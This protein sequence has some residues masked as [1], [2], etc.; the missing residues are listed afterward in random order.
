MSR[1]SAKA[2][3]TRLSGDPEVGYISPD[4]VMD[5]IDIMYDD[6]TNG[7]V[8]DADVAADADIGRTKIAGTALTSESTGIYNVLD[9]GAVGDGVTDDTD[10]IQAL[11]DMV[12]T[13]AAPPATFGGHILLPGDGKTYRIDG[14]LRIGTNVTV[15]VAGGATCRRVAAAASTA[16]IFEIVGQQRTRLCGRGSIETE[17]ASPYGVVHIG[18]V[19]ITEL[20]NVLRVEVAGVHLVGVKATGNVGLCLRSSFVSKGGV[21]FQNIISGVSIDSFGTGVLLT[22]YANA[23]EFYGLQMNAILDYCYHFLGSGAAS[24]S[25][26]ENGVIGGFVNSSSDVTLIKMENA[27]YNQVYGFRGEPGGASA[28]GY[29]LDADTEQNQLFI[30][31]NTAA[32]NI[33]LGTGN[34]VMNADRLDVPRLRIGGGPLELSGAGSPNLVVTAPP[35]S[36]YRRTDGGVGTALYVKETGTGNT[37]WVAACAPNL[38]TSEQSLCDG[39]WASDGSVDYGAA[40]DGILTIGGAWTYAVCSPK[41]PATPGVTYEAVVTGATGSGA[42]ALALVFKNSGGTYVGDAIS[43]HAAS[44]VARV[45]G[46][47][48][49][50]TATIEYSL[51]CGGPSATGMTV[52]RP[53]LREG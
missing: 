46:V 14:T 36:T 18:P 29:D 9:Y 30:T 10:A 7:P 22:E 31:A 51:F 23:N 47:A 33:D 35:G 45:V 37:G 5:A 50:T 49:A 24:D 17:K 15:E 26:C 20:A 39:G 21:T 38:L 2:K 25:C 41:I 6:M 40:G 19:D 27:L 48:P 42:F 52:T 28:V 43:A 16:P 8:V 11:I 13:Y 1:E 44:Q 4:D 3:Y 53:V 32:A 12:G 34:T